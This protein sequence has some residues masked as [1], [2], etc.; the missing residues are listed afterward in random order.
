MSVPTLKFFRCFALFLAVLVGLN[1]LVRVIA[2]HSQ[3]GRMLALLGHIPPRTDCLFLGNSLVQADCDLESFAQAWPNS[4]PSLTPLNLALGA[5]SPVEHCLILQQALRKP[6]HLKFLIYGF[7]DDQLNALPKG[8]C[9]DLVGNRAFSYYF[10]DQAA[11]FY[12]PGS[13][14]KRWQLRLLGHI[15]LFA[16]RSSLWSAV[17][18]FRRYLE[19]VGMPKHKTNRFGRVE[20]FSTLESKNSLSFSRRCRG[21]VGA[22]SGFSSS[23][24]QIL[25]LARQH[26]ARVIFVEMPMPWRHR[27]LFYSSPEWLGLRAYLKSLAQ[28]HQA[29]YVG[30]SDWAG[31]DSQFEDASHLNEQGAKMFSRR[32]AGALAPLLFPPEQPGKLDVAGTSAFHP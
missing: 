28:E 18:R 23:I 1:L 19:D 31:E 8:D 3:R 24:N 12:A 27:Q 32:L 2:G 11:A 29:L 30:A 20:D 22:K 9:S 15:P 26:G 13:A 6:L 21:I 10:P 14:W 7:S 16:E 25:D 17:E 4:T 5:T